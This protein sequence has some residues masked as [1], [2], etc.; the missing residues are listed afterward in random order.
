LGRRLLPR[1]SQS[2]FDTVVVVL[3]AVAA[4]RLVFS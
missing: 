2:T 4:I 3:A 1:L